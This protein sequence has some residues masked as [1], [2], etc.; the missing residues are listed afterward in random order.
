VTQWA[1]QQACWEVFKSAHIRL[2]DAVEDDLISAAQAHLQAAD[3]RKQRVIDTGFE[4]V[5][6]V[7]ALSPQVWETVYQATAQVPMSPTEKNLVERFGLRQGRVPSDRQA[8]VLLR[9]FDRM[10]DHGIIRRDAYQ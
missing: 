5:K 9:L 6:R 2:D 8:A 4:V 10:A 1:K 3:D 7:L